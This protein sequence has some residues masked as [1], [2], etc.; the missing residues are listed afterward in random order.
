MLYYTRRP[1]E[2]P[3]ADE[4]FFALSSDRFANVETF[5]KITAAAD[6]PD[7]VRGWLFSEEIGFP[8]CDGCAAHKTVTVDSLARWRRALGRFPLTGFLLFA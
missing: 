6:A 5:A 3:L 2:I 8:E 7:N 1:E 4:S